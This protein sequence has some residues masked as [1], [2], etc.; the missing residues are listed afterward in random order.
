MRQ[1]H[2]SCVRH[3]VLACCSCCVMTVSG[4]TIYRCGSSYGDTPCAGASTIAI[5]DSRSAAQ[6]AQ[7]DAAT[8]QTRNLALQLERERLALE[9]SVTSTRPVPAGQKGGK[10]VKAGQPADRSG[11]A[12]GA[13]TVNSR[14]ARKSEG[15]EILTAVTV[16]PAKKDKTGKA[17]AN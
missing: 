1:Q 8:V 10:A 2:T 5:D 3:L 12:A 14:P 7:T 15:L 11:T 9:K 13:K 17:S 4:Q 6:K 16:P